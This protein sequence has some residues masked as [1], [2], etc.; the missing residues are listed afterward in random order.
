MIYPEVWRTDDRMLP[1]D[2]LFRTSFKVVSWF[3]VSM[4]CEQQENAIQRV[5]AIH[6]QAPPRHNDRCNSAGKCGVRKRVH[7]IARPVDCAEVR[8]RV[9]PDHHQRSWSIRTPRTEMNRPCWNQSRCWNRSLRDRKV[10]TKKSR[11]ISGQ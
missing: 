1:I 3:K 11:T 8:P 10:N 5:L 6:K 7:T 2:I 9:S 4:Y